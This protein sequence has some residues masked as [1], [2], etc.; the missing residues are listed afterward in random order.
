DPVVAFGPDNVVYINS[1]VIT[2]DLQGGGNVSQA[3]LAMSTS[4][5]GGATWGDP[6]VM[7]LNNATEVQELGFFD[8][9]NW[10]TVDMS[11][12]AGHHFGRVYAVWDIQQ[13]ALYAYCDPDRVGA[14]TQGCDQL[15]NW[16]TSVAGGSNS[17]F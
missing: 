5:D 14:T 8:D 4:H 3:G 1:L 12:A 13:V 6:I 17:G 9:K 15:S 2:E 10:I 16:T 7:Q 11:H